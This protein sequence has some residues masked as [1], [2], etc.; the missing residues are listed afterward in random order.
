[1]SSINWLEIHLKDSTEQGEHISINT[2][3][4]SLS[5]VR[6]LSYIVS[7][8]CAKPYAPLGNLRAIRQQFHSTF[9]L[10]CTALKP[11]SLSAPLT[12]SQTHEEDSLFK[13]ELNDLASI[14]HFITSFDETMSLVRSANISGFRE[15]FPVHANAQRV[16]RAIESLRL[17]GD[18]CLEL[19]REAKQDSVIFSSIRDADAISSLSSSIEIKKSLPKAEVKSLTLIARVNTIDF[20][21]GSFSAESSQGIKV[22][23][24]S[25]DNLSNGSE[26]LFEAPHLEIGGEFSVSK[27]GE[28]L[29]L[30]NG[31]STRQV[32]TSP[33][34][35]DSLKVG[36]EYLVAD[37]KLEFRVYF[38]TTD[39]CYK[40][41]G[42]FGIFLYAYAREELRT[43]LFEILESMWIRIA[44][45]DESRL[46]PDASRLKAALHARFTPK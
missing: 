15:F 11:G 33:I 24:K 35:I 46:A 10:T 17:Q 2:L 38:D 28:P 21:Q 43:A 22:D 14:N 44:L 9:N 29:E 16:I 45:E 36:N 27:E 37:P 42:D 39:E 34:E 12:L 19:H 25:F 23:S 40:L 26:Q 3:I 41:K 13:E 7:S 1:M 6:D 18:Y 4:D 32:D 8:A 30:V 20:E 5:S 31:I